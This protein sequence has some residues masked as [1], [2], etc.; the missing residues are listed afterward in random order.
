MAVRA[1]RTAVRR[2]KSGKG[3]MRDGEV[4]NLWTRPAA[5]M[6]FG[7]E[8]F[9]FR[10]H[11]RE[12]RLPTLEIDRH[13]GAFGWGRDG[14]RRI[15]QM[16]FHVPLTGR[17]AGEIAHGDVVQ[18]DVSVDGGG[19]RLLWRLMVHDPSHNIAAGT[20]ALQLASRLKAFEQ[21]EV[22]FKFKKDK[23][24][25]HGWTADEITRAVCRRFRVR[26]GRLV[27]GR[28][29]IKKLVEKRA[30]PMDVIKR[31]WNADRLHTGRRYNIDGSRGILEVIE[32]REPAYMLLLGPTIIDA[33]I[34][35]SFRDVASAVVA[36]TT[37]KRRDSRGRRRAR[38]LQVKVVDE[39]R[40]RR[41]GYIVKHIH[42]DPSE[43]LD[44][45]DELR[46]H[47]LRRLARLMRP[48]QD[49]T[50]T[51]A[52]IPWLDRGDA[53]RITLP[54]A[55]LDAICFVKEV[56]H[57]VAPGSYTVT[58]TV[59]WA[60]PWEADRRKARARRKKREAAARRR[61]ERG[62]HA[63]APPRARKARMRS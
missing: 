45:P 33:T 63:T 4:R 6:V 27:R 38:K 50:F 55:D 52:G 12:R 21:S 58:V 29:R 39:A 15:G 14:D 46:R 22:S 7:R 56:Q 30:S 8:Q 28:H 53:L 9:R 16:T 19:W 23:A 49:L 40:V 2:K 20:I 35:R 37:V 41:F 59:G 3:S 11:R 32:L 62:D 31:A 44:T 42:P 43:E 13:V 1:S 10:L 61:R 25:P 51:H 18:C 47:A 5:P 26:V 36:T 48:K 57:D 24:H 34:D 17:R 60:D 54:D